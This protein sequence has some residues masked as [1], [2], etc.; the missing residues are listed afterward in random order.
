MYVLGERIL[1]KVF[2]DEPLDE[3]IRIMNLRQP[4]ESSMIALGMSP[5]VQV[6]NIIYQGT[7]STSPA[8]R[9]LVNWCLEFGHQAHYTMLHDK[10]FLVDIAK[11][12]SDKA[13]KGLASS[14][15]RGV[16]LRYGGYRV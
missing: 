8:R 7:T 2:R 6:V 14:E 4:P 9:L 15:F 16:L 13:E 10:D 11:S 12:F 5:P 3:C 1:D